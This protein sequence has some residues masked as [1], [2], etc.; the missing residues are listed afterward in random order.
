MGDVIISWP[1]AGFGYYD[2]LIDDLEKDP[3]VKAATPVIEVLGV[4]KLPD[5]RIVPAQVKG[6]DPASFDSVTGFDKT[7]WWRSLDKPIPMDANR[8]DPRLVDVKEFVD[9]LPEHAAALRKAFDAA[10]DTAKDRGG[11][12]ADVA[13]LDS[14]ADRVGELEK[15]GR[16]AVEL[17]ADSDE[18]RQATAAFLHDAYAVLKDAAGVLA[19]LGRRRH[20]EARGSQRRRR[21]RPAPA[22]DLL[23]QYQQALLPVHNAFL[24]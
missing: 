10:R 24:H 9:V 18:R 7:L 5:N 12:P 8:Q 14:L 2:E 4:I 6:I 3:N 19:A 1:S 23:W 20:A 21:H 13:M 16:T 11:A 22:G 15:Q 17:K